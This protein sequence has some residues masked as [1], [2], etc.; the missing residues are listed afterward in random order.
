MFFKTNI[1]YNPDTKAHETYYRLVESFRDIY[2]SVRNRTIVNAGFIDHLSAEKLISI[3]SILSDKI[4]GKETIAFEKDEDINYHVDFLFA[5]MVKEKKIDIVGITAPAIKIMVDFD[6]IQKKNVRDFGAESIAMQALE[7]LELKTFFE[8]QNWSQEQINLSLAQIV[9]RAVYPASENKTTQW[10]KENSSILELTGNDASI[11]TKDKL[12]KNALNLYKVKDSLE[13]H[14]SKKT[15]ELFDLDDKIMLYDLTNTY[16]EGEKRNSKLA[17][18][19]RSKE[20]R[21]DAKLVVLG[22]VVNQQGF[23]KYSS[24]FEG[25]MA[26]NKTL[27]DTIKKLRAS[28]SDSTKKALVV[29]DAGISTEEN[30]QAIKDENFDYLCVTRSYL[31]NYKT[32]NTENIKTI[33]DTKGQRIHLT[34]ATVDKSTDYYLK[35]HSEAKEV[36][37]RSMNDQFKTRFLLDLEKIASSLEKK[38]GVKT[39]DKVNIRIGRLKKQYGSINKYY[40]IDC[41]VNDADIV[42][43]ITWTEK[44]HDELKSREGVYFLRTSLSMENEETI[45]RCYNTIREIESSFRCLKTDLDL[46]PIYHKSDE[47]TMAHLHLGILAYWLVNTVRY[48][49]KRKK[50]THS[51]RE[52]VRIGNT[53]KVIT[54]IA[55]KED[56]QYI[57]KRKCSEPEPKLRAIYDALRYKQKLKFV[58]LKI[59]NSNNQNQK[60]QVLRH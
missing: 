4:K 29:I 31:K 8:S 51:W 35:C 57:G 16:F 20:K 23:I 1:K 2:G 42:T 21:S 34:K 36:K 9:S 3:Q 12:Y 49:L 14:L 38:H 30:L 39:R 56:L 44:K 19:G 7:Q 11:L 25:N 58:V 40:T 52:I 18:Y 41:E 10:M 50:I 6:S 55:Q 33:T 45:W 24:I 54:T 60:H 43:K 47:A 15:N 26:D 17:K 22:M 28:S 48:Q 32:S 37:E 13:Q 46:R 27:I 59:P 5:K 53:Q